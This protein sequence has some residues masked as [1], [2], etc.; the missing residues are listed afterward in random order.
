M[1]LWWVFGGSLVCLW[2]V[3]GMSLVGLWSPTKDPPNR[4]QTDTKQIPKNQYFLSF[5]YA[6]F[7]VSVWWVFGIC[8]VCLWYLFGGSLVSVWSPTKQIPNR[9]QTDTKNPA[10]RLAAAARRPNG[11]RKTAK[12]LFVLARWRGRSFAA[13]WI[14]L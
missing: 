12:R 14:I 4:Y 3:F 13:R 6:G 5:S 2:W 10:L 8:L 9:Y 1:G 7:L 11:R